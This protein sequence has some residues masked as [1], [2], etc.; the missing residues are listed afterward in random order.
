MVSKDYEEHFKA[1]VTR[2]DRDPLHCV[3]RE[4]ILIK[5]VLGGETIFLILLVKVS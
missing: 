4:A 5:N 2:K 1:S 3:V